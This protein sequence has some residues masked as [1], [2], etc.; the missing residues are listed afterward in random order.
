MLSITVAPLGHQ[1]RGNVAILEIV[2][3]H[4]PMRG[5]SIIEQN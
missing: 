1:Q 4:Q 2:Q 3:K 5:G